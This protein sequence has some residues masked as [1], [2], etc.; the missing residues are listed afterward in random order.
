[1]VIIMVIN[2]SFIAT[3][4][5]G[6]CVLT[7]YMSVHEVSKYSN[8]SFWNE[9]DDMCGTIIIITRLH[10]YEVVLHTLLVH[11]EEQKLEMVNF[12]ALGGINM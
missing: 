2:K 9:L 10:I 4:C 6:T 12:F 11:S 5:I 8:P 3:A 7:N 1:M